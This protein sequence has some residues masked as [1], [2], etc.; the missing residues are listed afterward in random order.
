MVD[1]YKINPKFAEEFFKTNTFPT[2]SERK[3]FDIFCYF[4]QTNDLA[5]IKVLTEKIEDVDFS[6]LNNRFTP[7]SLAVC[8]DRYDIA[9]HLLN[10]RA[11]PNTNSS[12]HVA[13]RHQNSKMTRLLLTFGAE[14]EAMDEQEGVTPLNIACEYYDLEITKD[15][16]QLG[17]DINGTMEIVE[18]GFPIKTIP[19]I[20]AC[21]YYHR[22][23]NLEFVE[24]LLKCQADLCWANEEGRTALFYAKFPELINLI[25][26]YGGNVNHKDI[27]QETVLYNA[28]TSERHDCVQTLLERGIDVDLR[29]IFGRSAIHLAVE[30]KNLEALKLMLKSRDLN[31]SMHIDDEGDN[32][33][34]LVADCSFLCEGKCKK[35]AEVL[36]CYGGDLSARNKEGENSLD[37]IFKPC[38]KCTNFPISYYD[39]VGLLDFEV[40]DSQEVEPSTA[41]FRRELRRLKDFMITDDRK[42]SLFDVLFF[43][44]GRMAMISGNQKMVNLFEN[45]NGFETDF[46]YYGLMLNYRM[47]KGLARKKLLDSVTNKLRAILSIRLPKNCNDKILD[48]IGESQ[49]E[50]LNEYDLSLSK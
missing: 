25:L 10:N 48:F 13:I 7:L 39:R 2:K 1:V 23:K 45:K 49:L 4:V 31:L 37:L 36:L 9:E 6:E 46:P 21:K 30:F 3:N 34:H 17:C 44:R 38:K 16:L 41:E 35:V 28:V 20:T 14:L 12:L 50:E 26:N 5:T 43:K 32:P 24:F 8:K 40:R 33:L 18:N 15:L 27:E 11:N 22:Y 29:N 19:L 47:R 42:I